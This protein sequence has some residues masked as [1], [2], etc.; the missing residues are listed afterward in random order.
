M[1]ALDIIK[2]IGITFAV[3]SATFALIFYYAAIWDGRVDKSE[4]HFIHIVNFMLRIGLMI[5]IVWEIGL[6]GYSLVAGNR[7]YIDLAV[8]WFRIM[9]LGLVMINFSLM[10]R[11]SIPGW[12]GPV[13]TAGSLYFYYYTSFI[14]IE[15]PFGILL[16]RYIL[17]T[18][19]IAL[20][21]NLFKKLVIDGR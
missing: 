14:Q 4:N 12:L 18:A 17:F 20:V 3:G 10:Q 11:H 1:E 5:L 6:M 21:F 19:V 2:H 16:V 7:P 9:L 8:P 13:L 15:I